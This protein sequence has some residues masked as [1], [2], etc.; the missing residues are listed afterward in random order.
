L[1]ATAR[2]GFEKVRLRTDTPEAAAFYIRHGFMTVDDETASHTMGSDEPSR[3]IRMISPR[4]GEE[5][6][7]RRHPA[8]LPHQSWIASP[9]GNAWRFPRA[10]NDG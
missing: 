1:L 3:G 2:D 7:R 6:L 8:V 10:R 5:R 9:K 4:H